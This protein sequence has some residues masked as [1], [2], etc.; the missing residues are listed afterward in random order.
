M[1]IAVRRQTQR[2]WD[3]WRRGRRCARGSF[4]AGLRGGRNVAICAGGR[5]LLLGWILFSGILLGRRMLSKA[6]SYVAYG[7][8]QRQTRRDQWASVAR[9]MGL[10]S[11]DQTIDRPRRGH[12]HQAHVIPYPSEIVPKDGLEMSDSLVKR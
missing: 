4:W 8:K 7:E 10:C 1:G 6:G 11:F 12:P 2:D 9:E 3:G 5:R